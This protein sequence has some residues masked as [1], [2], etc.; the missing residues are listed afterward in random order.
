MQLIPVIDLAHGVAVQARAGDRARY[1]P[2]ESI[3]TPGVTGDPVALVQAYRDVLGARECYLAD[4]DAI[5]GGALQH[6]L[7][8]DLVRSAAPTGLLVDAGAGDVEAAL[9]LAAL[10]SAGLIVGLETLGAFDRLDA[11]VAAAGPE[12]VVFSLDLRLGR[13]VIH[14]ANREAARAGDDAMALAA[15][16]VA[17]GVAALLLLDVGRVGTGGG[18]DLDLLAA[19]RRRFPSERLLAGGG[20]GGRSDLHRLRDA[21]CDGVML[22]TAFHT[23]RIGAADVRALAAPAQSRAS[24]SR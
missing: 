23:G 22:A 18:V 16:A 24:A 17:A 6:S 14:P 21:G 10:G 3:L 9:E 8:R 12:R 2:A 7:L 1:R 11:I 13:P 20:I 4:L 15:R 5:Q 19:L